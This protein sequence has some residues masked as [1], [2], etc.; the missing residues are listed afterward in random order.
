MKSQC[1]AINEPN[2]KTWEEYR[3]GCLMTYSGG[4]DSADT[5][6]A[7][8]HG[9]ETVFNLLEAEFPQ[10]GEIFANQKKG[11]ELC[12]CPKHFGECDL[13]ENGE[14]KSKDL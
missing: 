8:R 7:F 2:Y 3:K 10:P 11:P 13:C 4:N 12:L 14:C 5:L 9:M 1:Q 6:M